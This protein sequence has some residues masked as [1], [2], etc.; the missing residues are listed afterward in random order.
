MNML[1]SQLIE[2]HI[3]ENHTALTLGEKNYTYGELDDGAKKILSALHKIGIRCGD[4]ILIS[5]DN[6]LETVLLI[7]ACIA[8]GIVII[9]VGDKIGSKQYCCIVENCAPKLIFAGN[10]IPES[11]RY[12]GILVLDKTASVAEWICP[13][14]GAVGT[15]PLPRRRIDSCCV[16]YIIYTS[17]SEGYPR[18]VVARYKQIIF[19]VNTINKILRHTSDD[20]ILSALPLSFDYGLY[21]LFLTFSV[22]AHLFLVPGR[23]FQKIP[24]MLVKNKITGWPGMPY[25]FRLLIKTRMLE[26]I[27]TPDLRYITSTGEVFPI[28]LIQHLEKLFPE[29]FIIPMYG[30]TECKRVSIMPMDMEILS[31]KKGSCGIPM[32]GTQV[33]LRDVQPETGIGE[34]V[35]SGPNVMDG[36]WNAESET[37]QYFILNENGNNTLYTGDLFWIDEDGYLFF[38]GRKKRILKIRGYRIGCAEIEIMA[39]SIEGVAECAVFGK[40]TD[41]GE[42]RACVCIV[43]SENETENIVDEVRRQL[44]FCYPALHDIEIK[45]YK[46]PFSRNENGKIDIRLLKKESI[47]HD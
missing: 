29:T 32:P 40:Q 47:C 25:L 22:G 7:L 35:V 30:L 3:L 23:L 14:A 45:V 2:S 26:R 6:D 11:W 12:E 42:E 5:S 10:S 41:I 17:G 28:A 4:R 44:A 19:C 8:G 33:Y 46:E 16:G 18:G 9:P 31:S 43:S 20:R 37:R 21:Q 36:Y 34:L 15:R 24:G 27:T 39:E 1:Y 13:G 38:K